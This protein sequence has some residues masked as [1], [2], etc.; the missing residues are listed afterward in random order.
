MFLCPNFNHDQNGMHSQ[1]FEL[2]KVLP[3]SQYIT[4][5]F[6]SFNKKERMK[7][8]SFFQNYC[9]NYYFCFQ[10][11]LIQFKR[12][13]NIL[14]YPHKHTI[15]SL[16]LKVSFFTVSKLTVLVGAMRSVFFGKTHG[17]LL[18]YT[19]KEQKMHHLRLYSACHCSWKKMHS[20]L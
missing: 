3:L 4:R 7:L 6:W 11:T 12:Q 18:K 14:F 17:Q 5:V 20:V 1:L 2:S 15:Q 10:W 9:L 16:K 19:G 13:V 8:N